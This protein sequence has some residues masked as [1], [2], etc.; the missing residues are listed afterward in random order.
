MTTETTEDQLQGH[1]TALTPYRP[2][3]L[4]IPDASAGSLEEYIRLA[5]KA[6]I[7]TAER[8]HELAVR[9]Q[10]HGDM[11]A[12]GELIMSHLRLVISIARQY[13]GYGLPFADLIQEGN[14]GLMKAVKRFNPDNGARLV[15]FAMTW[16]RSEI[17]D[18]VLKNW[19]LVKVATTKSQRKLFFNLRKLKEDTKLLGLEDANRI[20]ET[21]DVKPAEVFEMEKRMLGSDIEIDEPADNQES[22]APSDWLTDERDT[23]ENRIARGKYENTIDKRLP[24]AVR[25][26]DD[27]SRRIIEAR[28]LY[29]DT[30][31][32]KGATL[33]DLAKEMGVSQERVRQLEKRA[34][35]TLKTYLEEDRDV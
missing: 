29:D 2:T 12:A 26:L 33:A 25:K 7:L 27:R 32:S 8:E 14:V 3:P 4:A 11:E 15:T 23:P 31:G 18:Y 20:A 22:V 19:R 10:E 9:L 34:F 21:L 24:A 35:S 30:D 16:I 17:Q 1:T 6:P 5:N 13:Q 28:W